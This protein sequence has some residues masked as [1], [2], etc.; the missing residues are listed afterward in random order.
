[1]LTQ[2]QKLAKLVASEG[3]GTVAYGVA[4]GKADRIVCRLRRR[5]R[6]IPASSIKHTGIPWEIGIAETQQ[7]LI[8]CETECVCK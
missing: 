1:M 4:K 7:A 8:I 5:H 6:R 3:V 2:K